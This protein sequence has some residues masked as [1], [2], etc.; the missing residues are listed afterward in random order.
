LV[1]LAALATGEDPR[2][3]KIEAPLLVTFPR[4]HGAHEECRTEWWYATGIVADVEDGARFG[5]QLTIFRR[6][7][8]FGPRSEGESL[9]AP[10]Q[11]YAAH[12]VVIDL[13]SGRLTAAE[14]VRRALPGLA[15]ASST[16]LD[17]VL[18]GWT[19]Q[20]G[21]DGCLRAR[22]SDREK[23][24]A[25]A[26]D[27]V[28]HKALVLHGR[29]G[30]SAKGPEAG[31]ASAYASWTRLAT[32]GTLEIGGRTRRVRGESWFDHEW[33]STQLGANVAG[34]DW[35]GL[36][37]DDGRELM[38]YR[39]RRNDG[40][41]VAESSGTLVEKD[42]TTR[43]IALADFTLVEDRS[44][45]SPRTH[46]RYGARWKLAVP[47]AAIDVVITPVTPDCEIDATASTGNV[48]WE[49]PVSV[50]G[51]VAGAGYGE[52]TGYAGPLGGKL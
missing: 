41:I 20:L 30:V 23:N 31:N 12:C 1:L 2:W 13:S 36:R 50:A 7:V 51:S 34:W 24:I 18:E 11:V 28:P 14:R 4:D 25:L 32:N 42:G 43:H 19:F 39:L 49:G 6:G 3:K 47:S 48:Y 5:W 33:G 38:L 21:E 17:V 8:E 10:R 46:G 16:N 44:W 40:G 9:L 35:F 37:F 15:A 45:E 27:L 52:L 26:L 22:A 29:D